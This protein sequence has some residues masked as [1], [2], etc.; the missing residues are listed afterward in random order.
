MEALSRVTLAVAPAPDVADLAAFRTA[1]TIPPESRLIFTGG[2]LDPS[3]GVKDA[4]W[5]F[6]MLRFE[7]LDLFL[8]VFG[9]GPERGKLEA[10]SRSLGRGDDR[11][12]FAG[13]RPDLASLVGQAAVVWATSRTGGSNFALEAMAAARPVVGFASPDL[14]EAVV[15]GETGFLLPA[16][17]RVRLTAKTRTLLD[18][19]ALAGK[20]GDAGRSRVLAR[21]GIDH[22]SDQL[23]RV[24]RE[25]AGV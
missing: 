8:V 21:H 2:T 3:S 14:A 23:A 16:G 12:R 5:A 25:V 10:L 13:H 15:E 24:Y 22:T 20:L 4:I 11:V 18:D 9:D 7:S 1:L 19:P 6:D 17:D